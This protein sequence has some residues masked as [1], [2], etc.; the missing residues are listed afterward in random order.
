MNPTSEPTMIY[1]MGHLNYCQALPR[2]RASARTDRVVITPDTLGILSCRREFMVLLRTLVVCT[3]S[4][5]SVLEVRATGPIVTPTGPLPTSLT[6]TAPLAE[7]SGPDDSVQL[8]VTANFA[9]GSS[10]DVTAEETGIRYQS[11]DPSVLTVD[12]NGLVVADS[13]GRAKV[14]ANLGTLFGFVE[15]EVRSGLNEDCTASVLNRSVQVSADGTFAIPNVPATSGLIR[16]RV[17]CERDGD[18]F[19]GHSDLLTPIQNGDTVV[20]GIELQEIEPIPVNIKL[21]SPKVTFVAAGETAQLVVTGTLPD[22][23]VKDFTPPS[24]GASYQSS[25]P[26]LGNVTAGGL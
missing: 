8:S 23:S 19:A 14:F 24:T 21:T 4:L 12:S 13:I 2:V 7:L 1:S 5:S 11:N 10:Q 15:I 25:N 3:V 17:T 16:I 20:S 26:N 18:F 9:D 22:G 6:V